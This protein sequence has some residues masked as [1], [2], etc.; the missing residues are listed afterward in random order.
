MGLSPLCREAYDNMT[1]CGGPFREA[2]AACVVN[3]GCDYRLPSTAGFAYLARS[4]GR[5]SHPEL[6]A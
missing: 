3:A 4:I 5:R 2:F 6:A 1:R